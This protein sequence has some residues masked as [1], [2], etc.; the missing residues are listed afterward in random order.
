MAKSPFDEDYEEEFEIAEAVDE[1]ERKNPFET[2]EVRHQHQPSKEITPELVVKQ[3]VQSKNSNLDDVIDEIDQ[4]R[5]EILGVVSNIETVAH[6]F[7]DSEEKFMNLHEK[8]SEIANNQAEILDEMKKIY[9]S[10]FDLINLVDKNNTQHYLLESRVKELI[11]D[12][13][14][15]KSEE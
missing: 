14:E 12:I 10:N 3:Q 1:M 5:E 8:M 7:A 15:L 6:N 11:E 9:K 13:Q 2:E 4:L